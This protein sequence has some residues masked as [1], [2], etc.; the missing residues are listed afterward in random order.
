M[1]NH[2]HI[3]SRLHRHPLTLCHGDVHLDNIFFHE[4][5]PGGCALVDFGNMHLGQ[6]LSDVAFFLA[7]NVPIDTRRQH[8]EGLLRA[9]HQSLLEHGVA[10]ESYPWERCWLDYRLQLWR[11]FVAILTLSPSFA[12]QHRSRTGMFAEAPS[13]S[14]AGLL[15]MYKEFNTRLVAALLDH[16][17]LELALGE[18][19]GEGAGC[20]PSCYPRP[21]RLRGSQRV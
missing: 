4:R 8:E 10:E 16:K 7:T 11:P 5:F 1:A 19:E 17:W 12:E 18:E 6:G 20:T 2:D 3:Y 13:H 15:R 21:F 9:Y 14:E